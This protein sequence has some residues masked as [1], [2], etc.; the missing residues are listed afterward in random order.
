[1]AVHDI[2]CKTP[3]CPELDI[4]KTIDDSVVSIAQELGT[5]CI[6]GNCQADVVLM[7]TGR[8]F[9]ERGSVRG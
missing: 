2:T 9:L 1:M 5:G 4:P 7:S 8:V 6:C 3:G